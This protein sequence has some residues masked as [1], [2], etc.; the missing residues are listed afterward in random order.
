M[1][2]PVDSSAVVVPTKEGTPQPAQAAAVTKMSGGGL[3][4]SPL[5]LGGGKRR[6]TKRLSKK[7]LRMFKKGSRS[8]LMKLM[9]GGQEADKIVTEGQSE[10]AASG[11]RRKR[12]KRHS[13]RHAM[14][15]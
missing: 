3:L 13:R 15:Y 6:K 14:L 1:P 4:L 12:T 10:G 2:A 8:K 5:P 7:V 9:K 11:G